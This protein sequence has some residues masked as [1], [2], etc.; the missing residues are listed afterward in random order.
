MGRRGKKLDPIFESRCVVLNADGLTTH[1]IAARLGCSAPR[2]GDAL[3]R[4]GVA[5]PRAG[6]K[7][8]DRTAVLTHYRTSKSA[9]MTA[10][11]MG[12]SVCTVL[13]WAREAGAQHPHSTPRLSYDRAFF[14][15]Y[16]REACYWAGFIAADG[17]IVMS[18]GKYPRVSIDL[19]WADAGH[20]ELLR[21]CT[22]LDHTVKKVWRKPQPHFRPLG[23]W[24]ACLAIACAHEWSKALTKRFNIEPR[25]SLVTKAPP[26]AIPPDGMWHYIRGYFD[27]DGCASGA[28]R[29][30]I[31]FSCG[32]ESYLE[33]IRGKFGGAHSIYKKR[34]AESYEYGPCGPTMRAAVKLMYRDSTPATRLG[35]KYDLIV[36]AGLLEESDVTETARGNHPSEVDD[37]RRE[38]TGGS[39][40]DVGEVRSGSPADGF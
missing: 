23:N 11:A 2:V 17:G 31:S 12:V 13:L 38:D 9:E 20:L 34:D 10:A 32:C 39:G 1:Q 26:E 18:Q 5:L 35:R 16:S 22:R 36:A 37:R 14:D 21:Q 33:W 7:P 3:R 4:Q 27:G 15:T 40:A 24:Q 6:R 19:A 30:Q 28:P 29:G 8:K 25:K